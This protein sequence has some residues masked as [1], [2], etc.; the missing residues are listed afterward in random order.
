MGRAVRTIVKW[1]RSSTA[2]LGSRP[3]SMFTGIR[4]KRIILRHISLARVL[5]IVGRGGVA[6]VQRP[7]QTVPR[8]VV[9]VLVQPQAPAVVVEGALRLT[10]QSRPHRLTAGRLLQLGGDAVAVALVDVLAEADV[11]LREEDLRQL[12]DG[13]R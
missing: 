11:A 9:V 7:G 1:K 6:R 5:Q 10:R 8:P 3:N 12:V 4:K 13:L 2:W